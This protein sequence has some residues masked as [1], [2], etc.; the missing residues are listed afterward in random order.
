MAHS[1]KEFQ[2][3]YD[4][5]L[6]VGAN[7]LR[8]SGNG[9]E[10]FQLPDGLHFIVP[11]DAGDPRSAKNNY[12]EL[13][14]QLGMTSEAKAVK[15]TTH[16][17]KGNSKPWEVPLEPVK[18]FN[19]R[20]RVEMAL[21][22]NTPPIV[23]QA[24]EVVAHK[25]AV[26]GYRNI[27]SSRTRHGNV[28]SYPSE[29]L[30]EANRLLLSYGNEAAQYYLKNWRD[31]AVNVNNE[32]KEIIMPQVTGLEQAVKVQLESLDSSIKLLTSFLQDVDN[33]KALLK[34]LTEAKEQIEMAADAFKTLGP[35]M[36]EVNFALPIL[37]RGQ[38][39]IHKSKPQ[40]PAPAKTRKLIPKG[41]TWVFVKKILQTYGPLTQQN[42]H[43]ELVKTEMFAHYT[44]AAMYPMLNTLVARGS[45]RKMDDGRYA[46]DTSIQLQVAQG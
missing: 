6:K 22:L 33:A 14:R 19:W 11:T 21:G 26:P 23:T 36:T 2:R 5:L 1:R 10:V 43:A 12:F 32:P 17:K 41:E 20:E 7:F 4:L 28:L 45:L 3:T 29:I 24:E 25:R 31:G 13:R 8:Y 18:L 40:E 30:A 15:L 42:I 9:H 39:F 16:V 44:K 27:G 46:I 37:E 35:L 34:K 38:S